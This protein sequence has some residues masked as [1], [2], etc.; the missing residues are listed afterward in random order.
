MKHK[1]TFKRFLDHLIEYLILNGNR[2]LKNES[3]TPIETSHHVERDD[4]RDLARKDCLEHNSFDVVVKKWTAS[5]PGVR[6]LDLQV[7]FCK[8][9]NSVP[10]SILLHRIF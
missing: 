8:K 3:E 10:I 4:R 6:S 2:G 1:Y 5:D 7:R 9:L